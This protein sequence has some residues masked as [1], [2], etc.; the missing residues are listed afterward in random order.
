MGASQA[1]ALSHA[2]LWQGDESLIQLMWE[3]TQRLSPSPGVRSP[4]REDQLAAEAQQ[5]ASS[6]FP[7]Q[8][9]DAGARQE[10]KWT[11][12]SSQEEQWSY[13][14]LVVG[15]GKGFSEEPVASQP[16]E[17]QNLHRKLHTR[18]PPRRSKC[19]R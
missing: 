3:H 16:G 13:F 12:K 1:V 8:R 4:T 6:S 7:A 18:M 5:A 15:E 19:R 2:Y 14:R 17:S 9:I 10:W 11:K